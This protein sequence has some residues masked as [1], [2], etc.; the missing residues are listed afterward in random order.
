VASDRR[1][2]CAKVRPSEI[3]CISIENFVLIAD[4]NATDSLVNL[5]QFL[6]GDLEAVLDQNVLQARHL[7]AWAYT[8][9]PLGHPLKSVL[10]PAF[11]QARARHELIKQEVL[12]L[13]RAW[14]AVGIVPILYK[15]FA[16]AE[17]VY[18]LPGTR[19]HGD[20]DVLVHPED[21]WRALEVGHQHGWE[22]P[23]EIAHW[24]FDAHVNPRELSLKKH[25]AN[26]AFDVHQRLVPSILPLSSRE[27]SMT[28]AAWVHSK[29]IQWEGAQVRLLMKEDAF[30][31]GLMISRCWGL[32]GWRLK[33][34]DLLDG[35]ALIRR[36]LTL[37]QLRERANALKISHTLD[38]FLSFC[39][40]FKPMLDLRHPSMFRYARLEMMTV[41]EHIPMMISLAAYRMVIAFGAVV[42]LPVLLFMFLESYG[43]LKRNSDLNQALAILEYRRSPITLGIRH[44]SLIWWLA[45]RFKQ[46]S[47]MIWPVMVYIALRRQG[48]NAVFKVGKS[49]GSHRAWVEVDG[50]PLPEFVYEHGPLEE[51]ELVL[52]RA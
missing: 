46:T 41:G 7:S 48:K 40:P 49:N 12:E 33:S 14:N 21:F 8:V 4:P 51:F 17:F 44:M 39:N 45:R 29:P 38:A 22:T 26:A 15:G 5:E 6:C 47:N 30:L 34:H 16:L 25:Q 9:L 13:V 20:V 10:K 43:T 50:K 2:F 52:T 3:H 27:H 42:V 32:D 37:N 11:I 28:E 19:F 35:L 23:Q 1:A 31:F 18:D 36:G 24:P